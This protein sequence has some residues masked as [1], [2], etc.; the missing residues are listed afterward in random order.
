MVAMGNTNRRASFGQ[1]RNDSTGNRGN[2]SGNIDFKVTQMLNMGFDSNSSRIALQQCNGDLEQ[3]IAFILRQKH[4]EEMVKKT[5]ATGSRA[6]DT[7][8]TRGPQSHTSN[9]EGVRNYSSSRTM[10]AAAENQ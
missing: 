1:R 6:K 9:S 2:G 10:L 3:A 4:Q 8:G 5:F 7:N